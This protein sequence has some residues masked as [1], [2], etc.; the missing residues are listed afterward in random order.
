LCPMF[1]GKPGK[2][3][4]RVAT[5]IDALWAHAG[6][7]AMLAPE[8]HILVAVSGGADSV[9]LLLGLAEL[10][11]RGGWSLTVAHF[12]HGIRAEA[13]ADAAFVEAL[14][15]KLGLPCV[16]GAA[17]VPA[18]AAR[19]AVSLEMAARDARYRFLLATAH[20]RG[21]SAVATAH[22]ADDQAETILLRIARGT[23]TTGLAGIRPSR[24][25]D[26]IRVLRPLLDVTRADVEAFLRDRGQ[27]WRE[28]TSNRDPAHARNR[29]RHRILP[30]LAAEL[31]PRV[32]EALCRLATLA[33]ADDEALQALAASATAA[34][35]GD[36]GRLVV[37]RW[38][39]L[40]PAVRSRILQ[41]WLQAAGIPAARLTHEHCAAVAALCV[42]SAGCRTL[43][44]GD[45]WAVRREYGELAVVFTAGKRDDFR[46]RLLVPGTTAIPA[47]GIRIAATLAP[48]LTR[49]RPAAPGTYPARASLAW[50][51]ELPPLVVRAWQPGDRMRPSGMRGSRKLQDVFVDLRVP[52]ARRGR[53]PVFTCGTAIVWLPGYRVAAGWEVTAPEAP[54][55]QLAVRSDT[56]PA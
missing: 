56:R 28:D 47:L 15:R 38:Q 37:A 33:H 31:N 36:N 41:G 18:A 51:P 3:I 16:V 29:V 4:M 42:S 22:T 34:C 10:A 43:D 24:D 5:V 39:P 14:A 7:D 44:I 19:D 23:G 25:C 11:A 53:I 48:G 35:V 17:D 54:N 45:G 13:A 21:C 49:D 2:E 55:L 50:R 26:G 46:V 52:A 8:A 9:A 12:N 27:T 40:Q 20:A 32:R 1:R 30:L 6:A